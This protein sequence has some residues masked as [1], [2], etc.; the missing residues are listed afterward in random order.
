MIQSLK[1][2][3]IPKDEINDYINLMIASFGHDNIFVRL[4]LDET[5]GIMLFTNKL[6]PEGFPAYS[7]SDML[8]ITDGPK[9]LK[10]ED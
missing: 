6:A 1:Y 8:K 7:E 3:I 10:I 2:Y 4:S 5:E 9:W